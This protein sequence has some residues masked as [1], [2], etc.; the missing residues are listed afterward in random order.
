MA[1]ISGALHLAVVP[2]AIT[3][4]LAMKTNVMVYVWLMWGDVPAEGIGTGC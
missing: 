1:A 4:V 2:S 3:H